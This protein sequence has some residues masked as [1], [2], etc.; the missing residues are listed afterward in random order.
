MAKDSLKGFRIA[1]LL[2]FI[3]MGNSQNNFYTFRLWWFA[4]SS[5]TL[6]LAAGCNLVLEPIEQRYL[7]RPWNP[8]NTQYLASVA[9]KENGVE[10]I[11]LKTP[12]GV[13]LHGWLKHPQTARSGERFPLVIVFGGARREMSWMIDR[14]E[15]RERWG[16]LYMNYRGFGLSEGQPSE[17]VVLQDASLIYDYAASRA[18]VD[19]ANIV[20]LGRS[21]GTYFTVALADK[22]PLRGVILATPFDSMAAL[23]KDRYPWLPAGLILNGRY[24]TAAIAPKINIPALIVLAENDDVTPMARGVALARAWGGPQRTMTLTGARHYGIERRD[25]FW[26]AVGEFLGAIDSA[27]SRSNGYAMEMDA[28]R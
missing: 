1:I 22:R 9:S 4:F 16:W 2:R 14:G 27:G 18:D 17:R 19:A 5:A 13:I 23:G 7:F 28:R 8:P 15:K 6:L 21:L 12:D 20:V 24:D 11:R 10:E 26:K 3:V 25:E